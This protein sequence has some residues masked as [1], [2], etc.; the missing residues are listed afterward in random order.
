M[1]TR[2]MCEAVLC[3]RS[4]KKMR[5]VFAWEISE[6]LFHYLCVSPHLHMG[7]LASVCTAVCAFNILTA[8]EASL[9][10]MFSSQNIKQGRAGEDGC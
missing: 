5:C 6:M 9:N 2:E 1:L 8:R 4:D 10:K 7:L 3:V